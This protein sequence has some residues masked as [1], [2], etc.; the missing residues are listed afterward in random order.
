MFH[1]VPMYG[2]SNDHDEGGPVEN[3]RKRGISQLGEELILG[4]CRASYAVAVGRARQELLKAVVEINSV[5]TH[6]EAAKLVE[7]LKDGLA[8]LIALG[9]PDRK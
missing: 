3:E 2:L 4:H 8:Y 1:A 5:S 7:R 9:C 6:S